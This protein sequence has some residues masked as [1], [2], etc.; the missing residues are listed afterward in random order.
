MRM[1]NPATRAARRILSEHP[2]LETTQLLDAIPAAGIETILSLHRDGQ[3]YGYGQDPDGRWW[4]ASDSPEIARWLDQGL[5]TPS[6]LH[7]Q[8]AIE[9]RQ[10]KRTG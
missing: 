7:L 6:H 10:W 4:L 9:S 1:I 5:S 8:D 3:T 2:G